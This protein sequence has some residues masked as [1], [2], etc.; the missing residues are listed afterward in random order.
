MPKQIDT[1]YNEGRIPFSQMSYTPDVPSTN[2]QPNEFNYGFN[3]ENDVRGIRSVAGEVEILTTVPGTPN[4]VTGGFRQ[5][6]EFWF[7]VATVEGQWLAAHDTTW[8]DITPGGT[9]LVGYAQNTN[10]TEVWNGT[11]PFFNDSLNPPMF[12]GNGDARMTMYSNQLPISINDIVYVNP[13]TQQ[14]QINA[15]A[16]APYTAGEK[17]VISGTGSSYYD[18]IRESFQ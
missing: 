17:I 12:W 7:I 3:I 16:V 4:F 9:P 14:I 11:V 10:I 2:L 18:G 6:G 5:G 15:Q 1:E 13:T 8:Y